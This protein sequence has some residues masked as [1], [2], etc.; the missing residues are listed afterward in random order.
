MKIKV[1]GGVIG[2]DSKGLCASCEEGA[3][4]EDAKNNIE[5]WCEAWCFTG[6]KPHRIFAPITRC[7]GYRQRGAVSKD[8]LEKIAWHITTDKRTGKIGFLTPS[9]RAAMKDED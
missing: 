8:A 9:D 2:G 6:S 3:I 1:H 4:R 7:T 5:V